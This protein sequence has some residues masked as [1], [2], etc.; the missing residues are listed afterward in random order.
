MR[1]EWPDVCWEGEPHDWDRHRDG[2]S[3]GLMCTVC[4]L[5]EAELEYLTR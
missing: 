1:L 4:G 2:Y 5:T 3:E